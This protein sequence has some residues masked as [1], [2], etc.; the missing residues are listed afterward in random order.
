VAIG[1]SPRAKDPS[2]KAGTGRIPG[3][4]VGD[5]VGLAGD[6]KG[7][8]AHARFY[9][10][11]PDQSYRLGRD[12]ALLNPVAPVDAVVNKRGYLITLDNWH[13]LG[14]GKVLA[15]YDSR[16]RTVSSYELEQLYTDGRIKNLRQ[17]V[18]SRYWRCAPVHFVDP[19][20]QTQLYIREALGGY[21]VL[22]IAS[23]A[24][25]YH[26]GNISECVPPEMP[27]R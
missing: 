12:V 8:Y 16:G 18:S 1:F 27:R 21:F 11:Q 26:A 23:G 4:S 9:A 2:G 25:T 5:T 13:N 3:K 19:A 24:V 20:D 10:L 14:Y 6:A 22:A 7:E 17:S 15:V